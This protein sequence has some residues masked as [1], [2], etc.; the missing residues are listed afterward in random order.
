MNRNIHIFI[1][2]LLLKLETPALDEKWL[3]RG[4]IVEQ[5]LQDDG[6]GPQ[7]A[8]EVYQDV[9]LVHHGFREG[10][11]RTYIILWDQPWQIGYFPAK[12]QK[13]IWMEQILKEDLSEIKERLR[14]LA[15][16][17]D[18]TRAGLVKKLGQRWNYHW[19]VENKERYFIDHEKSSYLTHSVRAVEAKLPW[20][21]DTEASPPG[22]SFQDLGRLA[23]CVR[24]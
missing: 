9:L 18:K 15:P 23:D 13:E 21:V 17:S 2:S 20:W 1:E 19:A 6:A 4:R 3:T 22:E 24:A 7:E 10:G 16:L 8:K 12:G 14:C 11:G 5:F